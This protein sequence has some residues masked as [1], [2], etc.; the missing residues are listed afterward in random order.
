M[1]EPESHPSGLTLIETPERLV[2][3]DQGW[4]QPLCVALATASLLAAGGV[5][6][7]PRIEHSMGAIFLAVVA[8]VFA[9]GVRSVRVEIDR[10]GIR[11]TRRILGIPFRSAG[12]FGLFAP[13][14]GT[15]RS[16]HEIQGRRSTSTFYKYTPVLHCRSGTI[17]L[18]P[19]IR[20]RLKAKALCARVDAF[21]EPI[22]ANR[23]ERQR[24][25]HEQSPWSEALPAPPESGLCPYC[26][27]DLDQGL[28]ACS[29]CNT[30]YHAECALEL[31]RCGTIGC[32][33]SQ[34]S[35]RPH[36]A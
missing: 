18:F 8:C 24:V 11:R 3:T 32:V 13:Q 17:E 34:R 7:G 35:R 28:V 15:I 30:P 4:T 36:K 26:R 16:T 19:A 9:F 20:D 1:A 21:L 5:A 14:T 12:S 6:S 33:H 23:E 31:G 2:V 25:V 22:F 29:G 10:L 27:E